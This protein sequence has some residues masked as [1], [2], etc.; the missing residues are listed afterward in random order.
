[1]GDDPIKSVV[2]H[3]TKHLEVLDD[4]FGPIVG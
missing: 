1:M 2:G 4:H 3:W